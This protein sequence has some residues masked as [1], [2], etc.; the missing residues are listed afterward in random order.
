MKNLIIT[1]GLILIMTLL[2]TFQL[3]SI[4]ITAKGIN[5]DTRTILEEI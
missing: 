1:I 2:N 3:E 5:E 4:I